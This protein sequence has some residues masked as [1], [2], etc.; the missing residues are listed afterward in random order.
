MNNKT[1]LL[2]QKLKKQGL[3]MGLTKL[4]LQEKRLIENDLRKKIIKTRR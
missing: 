4:T 3:Y 2:K 1:T